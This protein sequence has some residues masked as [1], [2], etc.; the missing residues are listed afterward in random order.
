MLTCDL[1]DEGA[2]RVVDEVT[3][4][5]VPTGNQAAAVP[6]LQLEEGP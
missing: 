6:L 2:N 1:V 5:F 4:E 3:F